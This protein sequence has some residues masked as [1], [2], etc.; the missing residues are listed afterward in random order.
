MT[1]VRKTMIFL[2]A[3]VFL[4]SGGAVFAVP[5]DFNADRRVNVKCPATIDYDWE[6]QFEV[7]GFMQTIRRLYH[8]LEKNLW[9]AERRAVEGQ[10]GDGYA[11]SDDPNKGIFFISHAKAFFPSG[12]LDS[13]YPPEKIDFQ[14]IFYVSEIDWDKQQLSIIRQRGKKKYSIGVGDFEKA[15]LWYNALLDKHRAF[16][17]LYGFLSLPGEA[18][19]FPTIWN[20][21]EAH[22]KDTATPPESLVDYDFYKVLDYKDGYYLLAQDYNEFDYRDNIEDFGIIG[23][24]EKKYIT[25]WRS[26]LYYHPQQKV[27]FFDDKAG[28]RTSALAGEI[29]KF[30]VDNVYLNGGF[31]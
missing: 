11:F 1:H 28:S 14:E 30:Y 7:D 23:W 13:L 12:S 18:D 5:P 24:V 3:G 21:W 2:L 26:R 15:F 17:P 16:I 25:L 22:K 4:F 8:E 10:Y 19:E 20:S 27:Q 29:N 31:F 9:A 6:G